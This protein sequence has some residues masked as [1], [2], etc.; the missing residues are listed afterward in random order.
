MLKNTNTNPT[1]F[2]FMKKPIFN[3]IVSLFIALSF[4]ACMDNK[5]PT[6][7]ISDSPKDV[8]IEISQEKEKV[9]FSEAI[10]ASENAEFCKGDYVQSLPQQMRMRKAGASES[11]DTITTADDIPVMSSET[12]IQK[13]YTDGSVSFL[14]EDKTTEDMK[15]IETINVHPQPENE[16]VTKTIIKNNVVSLY[17][18]AGE[19]IKTNPVPDMNMKSM[20]DS[21]KASLTTPIQNTIA[22][23]RVKRSMA[24]Q[25]ACSSGM[26]LVSEG[27][28]EVIMEMEIGTSNSS[29]AYRAKSMVSKKAVMRFSPD[30]SRMYSQKIYEGEQLTQTVEMEYATKEESQFSNAAPS[31][32]YSSLP[33]A[34]IKQVRRKSLMNKIDGTPYIINNIETYKKNQVIY[35]LAK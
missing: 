24:I 16:R 6:E 25:K 2:T 5:A 34:N 3:I 31:T 15:F 21:L 9:Q 32:S 27:P 19:L 17:N 8:A 13:I 29:L 35:N 10:Y 11:N 26:R 30:M 23:K 4:Q 28:T 7:T 12:I 20:L 18:S 22:A 14:S 1:K 33:D